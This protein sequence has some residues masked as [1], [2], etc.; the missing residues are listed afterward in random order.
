MEIVGE[1]SVT[2]KVR[3]HAELTRLVDLCKEL[4]GEIHIAKSEGMQLLLKRLS[5]EETQ[6][7]IV[8]LLQSQFR[9]SAFQMKDAERLVAQKLDRKKKT[10]QL[11]MKLA[12]DNGILIRKGRA[13]YFTDFVKAQVRSTLETPSEMPM[14][15]PKRDG[16]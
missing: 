13:Y 2:L 4:D 7:R 16:N 5:K 12:T 10:V 8:K 1:L 9:K 11:A 3:S 14:L 15:A 6:T